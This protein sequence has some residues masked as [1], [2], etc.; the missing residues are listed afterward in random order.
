MSESDQDK[1]DAERYRA[2]REY[3][4][5]DYHDRKDASKG[6]VKAYY[7]KSQ[8]SYVEYKRRAS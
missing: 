8:Q 1:I 6:L 2:L 7:S 4:I 5:I 3:G